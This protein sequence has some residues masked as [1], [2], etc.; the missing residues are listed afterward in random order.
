MLSFPLWCWRRFLGVPWTVVTSN[1]CIL[2]EI[3]PEYSS[4]GLMLKLRLRYFAHLM[5]RADLLEKTLM[6]RK[7]EGRRRR[8]WQ[9]MKWFDGTNESMDMSLIKLLEMVKDGET[10]HVAV[11]GVTRVR[12]ALATERQQQTMS[13]RDRYWL[14]N[15]HL[16]KEENAKKMAEGINNILLTDWVDTSHCVSSGCGRKDNSK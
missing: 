16:V 14:D 2:K 13:K 5:W 7:T 1:Q 10:W 8:W 4:E 3:S 15:I 11:R 6:M 12:H 9:R